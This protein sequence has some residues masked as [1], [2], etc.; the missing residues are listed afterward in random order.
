MSNRNAAAIGLRQGCRLCIPLSLGK[1]ATQNR[2]R[3]LS[4]QKIQKRSKS[5]LTLW[6][7]PDYIR[8]T[9]EGGAPLATKKFA[10]KSA[11]CEIQES[12]VSDTR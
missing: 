2:H 3:N 8:L 7:P 6:T 5:L 10:S 12:R 4:S 9:N 11:L 1:S